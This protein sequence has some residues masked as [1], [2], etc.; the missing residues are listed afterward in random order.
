M[1]GFLK[2]VFFEM[3][4]NFPDIDWYCDYC[5][6]YL[7]SQSGFHDGCG[8]WTCTKCGQINPINEDE[9]IGYDDFGDDDFGND[10]SYDFDLGVSTS[11]GR[12]VCIS[13]GQSISRGYLTVPWED[14]DNPYAYV[15]CPYCGYE[16]IQDGMGGD[17]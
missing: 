1:F 9:I 7:N 5:N 16:N 15:R 14:G 17:D 11:V 8:E 10:A 12:N 3:T 4:E 6:D 2:K 13:C